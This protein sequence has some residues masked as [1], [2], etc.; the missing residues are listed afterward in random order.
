MRIRV[1]WVLVTMF[2]ALL[3]GGCGGNGGEDA[4]VDTL[5]ARKR[6][7]LASL[8]NDVIVPTLSELATTSAALEAATATLAA[9]PSDANRVAAQAA[10]IAAIDVAQRAELMH[11]GPGGM[12]GTTGV[13]GGMDLRDELYSWPLTNEC[14]IDQRTVADTHADVASLE[15]AIVSTRGLD[16]LEYL[17]FVA[18]DGNRCSDTSALN[19]DGTWASFSADQIRARRAS[20]AHAAATLVARDA[21]RLRDLWTGG[22]AT[23][24]AT[25]GGGS[26]L[27]SS[28]QQALDDLAG[29]MLYLDGETRDMKLGEPAGFSMG[30][31]TE[32]CLE[33]LESPFA[34]RSKEN[35]LRNLEGFQRLFLGGA[36]EDTAALGLDDLLADVGQAALAAQLTEALETAI[37]AVEAIEGELG[38]AI[39]ATPEAVMA[40]YEAV[41]VAQRLFKVDVV[42]ALDLEPS[43]PRV[44]DDD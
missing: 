6:E 37:A 26:T 25:A 19:A 14:L 16:A 42:T 22:F 33:A 39:V 34:G 15:S 8:A 13:T 43:T 24:M 12:S 7:I 32:T 40:A 10:W 41:G 5:G 29:A 18:D 36:P 11:V 1:N 31:P 9:D 3:I 44:G 21:A 20:Y 23:E 38:A 2:G 30:C 4:G 27:F 28:A 35:I 17:L